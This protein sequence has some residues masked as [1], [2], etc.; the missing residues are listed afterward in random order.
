[1]T[2]EHAA[3]LKPGIRAAAWIAW[4]VCALSVAFAALGILFLF[5][6]G[7]FAVVINDESVGVNAVVA[8]VFPMVGALIA[9]RHPGNAIG[10]IFCAIGLF[11]GASTFAGEY[12]RYVLQT[13]PDSLPVGVAAVWIGTWAWVPG[14][15]LT[16]T[17]LLLLFPHGRLPSRRWRPVAWLAAL[18]ITLG[19]VTLAILPW[20]LLDV[21]AENPLGVEAARNFE[22]VLAISAG[23]LWTVSTLLCLSAL[24]VRFRR[25][26]GEERQQLKWFVYAGAVTVAFFHVPLIP[27]LSDIGTALQIATAPFLPAAAGIAILK[28]RLYD[29]DLVINRTLVYG[30]LTACVVGIYVLVVGYLGA[31]FQARGNLAV[32][33]GAAGVVAVLFAPLRERLQRAVNRLM[34]GE[35]DE[36]YAVVSRLGERLEATLAP[37]A[38]LPAAVRTVAEAL[39]LPFAAV[40]VGRDGVAF[41]TAAATGERVPDPL[42]LPLVYG[43]ETVG[44]L[45]LG[46]RPGEADFSPADRRLL[47]DL[48]RQIGVAVHAARLTGEAIRLS[49]DLRRS[50]AELVTAREEERRRLRRDLHDG[51]GPQLASLAMKAEAARD[52]LPADPTRSDA[53][54]ADVTEQTQEAVSD[55]RRLVYGLRPPALDDL[56]ASLAPCGLTRRTASTAAST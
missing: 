48:A 30:A 24:A 27:Q 55:V 54:L 4:S 6:H 28:H 31:L 19:A 13:E 38:V 5:L 15:G 23:A 50:R 14:V 52:L 10:W 47:D 22:V 45:V 20:D 34:Y 17:F 26:R 9:S 7:S 49:E 11:E 35:R 53:L 16:T 25:S 1:M 2:P 39:K 37:N 40:E 42:R 43:G 36:P 29:I 41:E 51:L 44:R 33:L 46:R 8:V 56:S 12:G 18:G 32:S 21:P 3:A